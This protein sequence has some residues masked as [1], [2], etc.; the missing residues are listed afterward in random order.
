M[1][2]RVE[3]LFLEAVHPVD[4]LALAYDFEEAPVIGNA[5]DTTKMKDLSRGGNHGNLTA[6]VEVPGL[7]GRARRFDNPAVG[8]PTDYV[9]VPYDAAFDFAGDF[10]VFVRIKPTSTD[11]S[12]G[13][14]EKSVGQ[15]VNTHYLL[16]IDGTPFRFRIKTSAGLQT[17]LSSTP[18]ADVVGQHILLGGVKRGGDIE[19]WL[20]DTKEGSLTFA[21]TLESGV[22]DLRVGAL[23]LTAWGLV[24]GE[25][26]EVW[27]TSY[28]PSQ[29]EIT[30]WKDNGGPFIIPGSQ[31]RHLTLKEAD[32][33][34]LD[35]LRG[36]VYNTGGAFRVHFPDQ[37]GTEVKLYARFEGE[38]ET[39]H[40]WTGLVKRPEQSHALREPQVLDFVAGD[41]VYEVLRQRQL[42][43]TFRDKD[44]GLA[45]KESVKAKCPELSTELVNTGAPKVDLTSDGMRVK[46]VA[47]QLARMAGYQLGGDRLKR[48]RFFPAGTDDS[49]LV[50]SYA[51]VD[52]LHVGTDDTALANV[53]RVQGGEGTGLIAEQP[54]KTAFFT[55][56]DTVRKQVKVRIPKRKVKEVE[57][58]TDPAVTG[59]PDALVIRVQ[60]DD[61]SGTAPVAVGDPTRDLTRHQLDP[62]FLA[63]DAFTRFLLPEHILGA[64]VEYWIIVEATGPG[65]QA[66]GVDGAGNLTYRAHFAFPLIEEV[67]DG[68]SIRRL[69]GLRYEDTVADPSIRTKE[70]AKDRAKLEIAKRSLAER[71]ADFAIR[72]PALL[73][74]APGQ[75][76]VLD[77][78]DEG[79]EQVA[80]VLHERTWTFRDAVMDVRV[81]MVEEERLVEASDAIKALLDRLAKAE[82]RQTSP[83]GEE[84][85]DVFRFAEDV[86]EAVDAAALT[87]D[88][89]TALVWGRRGVT[90]GDRW[91]FATWGRR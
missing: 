47:F 83:T 55:V 14:L 60:A 58:W 62:A 57:I 72:D 81:R 78:P 68:E 4:G 27:L 53:I 2:F 82:R 26:D 21:G 31:V 12:Q 41:Y 59:S 1:S 19:I 69:G 51:N 74:A 80:F 6:T 43:E 73:A 75:K 25:I 64:G 54:T 37:G 24:G 89:T 85:V 40:R 44:A 88:I 52:R 28:A 87:V 86:G 50:A 17:V 67:E 16:F 39:T 9:T 23:F 8:V 33:D 18:V 70:E 65:G 91:G 45:L 46:D 34:L 66:V 42:Y 71:V 79:L 38:T 11:A 32:E 61:G 30:A 90:A 13:I 76:V 7:F 29:A 36:T 84:L 77:L 35:E 22:G 63:T 15:T 20:G 48:V 10:G 56:T 3:D 5:L 49:G